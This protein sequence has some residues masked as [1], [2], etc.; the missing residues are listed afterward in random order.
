MNAQVASDD[1]SNDLRYL[2]SVL[3]VR[4]WDA[5]RNQAVTDG[6]QLALLPLNEDLTPLTE[7]VSVARLNPGGT[8]AFFDV[9]GLSALQWQAPEDLPEPLPQVPCLVQMLDRQGRFLPMVRVLDLPW[10]GAAPFQSSFSDVDPGVG[11]VLFSS[12]TRSAGAGWVSL[13]VDAWNVS[14]ERPA[15][16][17]LLELQIAEESWFALGNDQ[18]AA[19]WII[20]ALAPSQLEAGPVPIQVRAYFDFAG[21]DLAPAASL[22]D[23]AAILSQPPARIVSQSDADPAEIFSSSL[24]ESTRVVLRTEGQSRLWLAE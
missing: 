21:L 12:P 19:Q 11:V 16:H 13:R 14:A 10:I 17:A 3:G 22:P 7:K 2:R 1:T 20:P 6:L 8:F 5:T 24:G 18:G 4:F 9:P 23:Q 15:A